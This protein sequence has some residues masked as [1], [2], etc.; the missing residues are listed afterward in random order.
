MVYI[1]EQIKYTHRHDKRALKDTSLYGVYESYEDAAYI[2]YYIN[3][4][5]LLKILQKIVN[6][7]HSIDNKVD[8]IKDT[9]NIVEINK[10]LNTRYNLEFIPNATETI[11]AMVQDILNN[12]K[13]LFSIKNFSKVFQINEERINTRIYSMFYPLYLKM[14]ITQSSNRRKIS[15]YLPP[16]VIANIYKYQKVIDA[17]DKY[18]AL[19]S[20]LVY[21]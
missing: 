11:R 7:Y 12:K 3:R 19:E 18:K 10:L 14:H 20:T 5:I 13:I 2:T 17:S 8:M 21:N 15:N 16:E 4:E 1:V 6:S 9:C